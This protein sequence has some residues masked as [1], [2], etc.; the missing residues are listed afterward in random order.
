MSCLFCS[1]ERITPI[2]E[3]EFW[4]ISVPPQQPYLG[5]TCV[6]LK[7]HCCSLSELTADE[8]FDFKKLTIKLERTVRTAFAPEVF[9]WSCLMNHAFRETPPNP[10]VHWHIKPRYHATVD[11]AGVA[12]TDEEFGSH[13]NPLKEGAVSPEVHAAI[14]GKLANVW[15]TV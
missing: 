5:Y 15:N 6:F 4:K 14:E 9:N 3:T 12:F 11:F 7:R 13:Y 10:H 2:A 8:W 1:T